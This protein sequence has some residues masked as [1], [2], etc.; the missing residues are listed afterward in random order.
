MNT[1]G[2]TP[3]LRGPTEPAQ[4]D[5]AVPSDNGIETPTVRLPPPED[6]ASVST[7]PLSAQYSILRK[8][9]D[10]G[11]GVVYLARDNRLGRYVAIKR[12]NRATMA[13]LAMKK[14]FMREAKAIAAL[15]HIH[16][17]QVYA[18]GEDEDGPYIVMQ[19]VAGPGETA[20]LSKPAPSLTLGDKVNRDGPFSVND[21]VGLIT[22]LCRAVEYA[23]S[24]GVIHR[25]LKPTNVLLDES[26]EPKIVDFG[27]ARRT[28]QATGAITV[29]GEK[30]LSLGY[31]APEQ[32]S[33]SSTTDERAD[34]YGLGA[35]LYFSVTGQNPR[36]FRENDVPEPL[37]LPLVKALKTD[38]SKRWSSAGEF[39]SALE[40][41]NSPS[42][43]VVPTVKTAWRCKWCDT[44]N[45]VSMQYCG[46]CGW[47]GREI[48]AECGSE[49]RV[50][51]QFCG[52]CG[53][54]AREYE[55]A[56]RLLAQMHECW[57]QKHMERI[58]QQAGAISRFSPIGPNGRRIV[59]EAH[60]LLRRARQALEHRGRLKQRIP[61]ELSSENY[62]R[63]QLYI[64]EYNTIA[65]DNAFAV[66]LRRMPELMARRDIA[67]AAQ[68]LAGGDVERAAQFCQHILQE[69]STDN[70]EA[71]HMLGVIRH[72]RWRAR[73][74]NVAASLLLIFFVYIYSA[75]PVYRLM[76]KPSEGPY[77][78]TYG[79]I[80]FLHN[81]TLLSRPL[82]L[83][84][85]L[86]EVDDMFASSRLVESDAST[87][88]P[89]PPR[90]PALDR[91]AV[92]KKHYARDLHEIHSTYGDQVDKWPTLY[93]DTIVALQHEKQ[94]EGDFEAW[95][96]IQDELERFSSEP[97]IPPEE[98]LMASVTGFLRVLQI[99]HKRLLS[100]YALDKSRKTVTQSTRYVVRLTNLQKKLTMA[101]NMDAAREVNSEIKRAKASTELTEAQAIIQLHTPR[102][103]RETGEST[104]NA[105]TTSPGRTTSDARRLPPS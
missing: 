94:R 96:A 89:A 3:I 10:G 4:D 45:P 17:V 7:E 72:R 64:E 42:T 74:R 83:Y 38:R 71:R 88:E 35:I 40:L 69:L 9:G 29:P 81:S 27:L 100:S 75:A 70:P 54:D 15:N 95:L 82:N 84:A 49:T 44:I 48:C 101:G 46:E 102:G 103:T 85:G 25:D 39:A 16:I 36:Y 77:H 55:M 32:E 41:I 53:A 28:G 1:E 14:R 2:K 66:E 80:P 23:H 50:G 20:A 90:P 60:D 31:G 76:G 47:D 87:D 79:L 8:I 51:V 86:W 98:E 56:T 63:A 12:L 26:D 65:S 52:D 57:K 105:T 62:E 59:R 37:R 19:Y 11:M 5:A 68:A 21:A 73:V 13:Q 92:L 67:R 24:C 43:V 99:K 33:D 97:T 18:L 6:T 93:E 30:I 104:T 61:Q 78:S 34:V 91:L 58:E 22:K